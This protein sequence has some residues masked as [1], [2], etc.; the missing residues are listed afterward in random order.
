MPLSF[1]DF[2]ERYLKENKKNINSYGLSARELNKLI[3][4]EYE[5]YKNLY[6]SNSNNN[7]GAKHTAELFKHM[8]DDERESLQDL[9]VVNDL[10][11]LYFSDSFQSE[12]SATKPTGQLDRHFREFCPANEICKWNTMY[13]SGNRNDC[14]IHSFLT[15]TC[16]N[17]RRLPKAFKDNFAKSFRLDLYPTFPA[18]QVLLSGPAKDDHRAR[19]FG[20]QFL[21]DTDLTILINTYGVNILVFESAKT[22]GGRTMPASATVFGDYSGPVY[23]LANSSNIHYESVRTSDGQY[24]ISKS[25]AYTIS[26]SLI[27]KGLENATEKQC[28]YEIGEAVRYRGQKYIVL[29]REFNGSPLKCVRLLLTDER[30]YK[31][32]MDVNIRRRDNTAEIHR[33]LKHRVSPEDVEHFRGGG[34]KRQTRRRHMRKNRYTRRLTF[35]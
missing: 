8:S 11:K 3:E 5:I 6:N 31:E 23:L 7:A 24:S 22:E 10:I 30:G 21:E 17:F 1:K 14:I 18:V 13:S 2:K 25:K 34:T 4:N 9:K 29:Q 16:P 20:A 35:G 15:A 26:K 27:P 28:S 19:I 32:Y 33:F 12:E